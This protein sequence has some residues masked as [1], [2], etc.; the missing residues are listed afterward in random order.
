MIP[1]ALDQANT[2]PRLQGAPLS[3]YIECCR[4]LDTVEERPLKILPLSFRLKRKKDTVIAA[5]R[6]LVACRYIAKG[7]RP[8]G[9]P[10]R[11]RLLPA[12]PLYIEQRKARAA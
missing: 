2:D 10:R 1:S 4:C 3:L 12:P 9:E 11:Y 7:A 6:V 8:K 5:L